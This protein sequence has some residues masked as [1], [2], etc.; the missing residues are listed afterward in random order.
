MTIERGEKKKRK[1][2]LQDNKK[3]ARKALPCSKDGPEKEKE[4]MKSTR[5]GGGSEGTNVQR[6]GKY[7]NS[8]HNTPEG[9]KK[10]KPVCENSR[11]ERRK[12]NVK[13]EPQYFIG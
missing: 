4:I 1:T 5:A 12:K 3:Y 9:Y 10:E 8:G 7:I 11:K 6:V 13:T 2:G